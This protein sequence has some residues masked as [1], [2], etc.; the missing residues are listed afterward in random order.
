VLASKRSDYC[1]G[2]QRPHRSGVALVQGCVWTG[3]HPC[4]RNTAKGIL[5]RKLGKPTYKIAK[6]YPVI[7][8]LSCLGK[9]VEKV[10]A[11]HIASFCETNA[12]FHRGQ[13]GCRRGRG[14]LDAVAQLVTE[15]ES[16][17]SKKRTALALLLDVKEAFDRVSKRQ[18]LKRMIQ[19][20]IAGNIVR[21][22]DSFL[23]DRQ[24]MLVID[25]RTEETR[26]T[27]AGL[28]Q[29]SPVS[30]V[31]FILSVSA[32]FQWLEDRRPTFQALSFVDDIGSVIE[33]DDLVKGTRN[34]ERI[35]R[36]TIRWGSNNK[37]EFESSKT[38][39]PCVQQMPEGPECS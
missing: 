6:A 16:A 9:V 22:V 27:Q 39:N 13:F 33:C 4:T 21:W 3:Y 23:S 1:G 38:A 36:D 28:P 2:G 20:G 24:A 29:G 37:V 31:L 7:S 32:M 17:W 30:P 5:L 12:I 11:T 25:G 14:A 18:P 19:V 8:L 34:L 35:A 15:V 10:V 26:S